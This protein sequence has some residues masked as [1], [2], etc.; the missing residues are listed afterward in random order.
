M[1]SPSF[2][3]KYVPGLW[4]VGQTG[5]DWDFGNIRSCNYFLN[6]VE[7]KRK[8]GLLSGGNANIRHYIG[9]VYM[10]RAFV[11]FDKLQKLGDFP[12]IKSVLPDEWQTLAEASKRQPCNE[13]ARFIIQDL[14]SAINLMQTTA[15]DGKKNRLSKYCAYQLKSRVALFEATCFAILSYPF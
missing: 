9:E 8:A 7:A 1:A 11:Y 13:V 2:D 5:G 12:I 3:N 14:D 4:K 6:N 15:P 10:I